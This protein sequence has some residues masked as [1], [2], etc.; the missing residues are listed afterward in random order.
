MKGMRSYKSRKDLHQA[1]CEEQTNSNFSCSLHLQVP[2][3]LQGYEQ[4]EEIAQCVEKPVCIEHGGD[5][6]TRPFNR[7]IPYPSSWGAFPDFDDNSC[8]VV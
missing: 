2:K 5:T 3:S 1:N 6:D 7:F 8:D 4:N